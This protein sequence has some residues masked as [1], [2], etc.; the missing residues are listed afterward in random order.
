M[1]SISRGTTPLLKFEYPFKYEYVTAFSVTFAQDGNVLFKIHMGDREVYR[2]EN[3]FLCIE[4][5]QDET[6]QFKHNF[7][8]EAQLKILNEDG[9]VWV[10]DIQHYQVHR[11]LDTDPFVIK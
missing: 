10:G 5:T 3:Y 7:P 11:I 2:I 4:L 9:E 8:L 6:N 1:Q